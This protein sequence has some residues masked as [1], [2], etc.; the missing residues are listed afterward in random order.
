MP[1]RPWRWALGALGRRLQAAGGGRFNK[2]LV[3]EGLPQGWRSAAAA[4]RHSALAHEPST[5]Q[6]A[7]AVTLVQPSNSA[8]SM[9]PDSSYHGVRK[10]ARSPESPKAAR[11]RAY[12]MSVRMQPR[13]K[14]SWKRCSQ[15]C[16]EKCIAA[17]RFQ[18]DVST[19]AAGEC[20][21]LW[22]S[23]LQGQ[24]ARTA[25]LEVLTPL[26]EACRRYLAGGERTQLAQSRLASPKQRRDVPSRR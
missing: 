8:R 15:G 11:Q 21:K 9:R 3:L 12:K 22:V 17:G 25:C 4:A 23:R 13:L 1:C 6:S 18:R 14:L 24:W 5:I 2:R 20:G 10:L 26:C 7:I 19:A 16:R